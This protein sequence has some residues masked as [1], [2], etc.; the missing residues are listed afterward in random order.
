MTNISVFSFEDSEVRFVGTAEQ[1]EW[2]AQ[3]VFSVLG[4]QWDGHNLDNYDDDEKGRVTI[5]TPGGNQSVLTVT[6]PGLYRTIFKSRKP[7]AKRF[8]RWV[9]HDVLPSIRQTGNYTVPEPSATPSTTPPNSDTLLTV[10]EQLAVL[11]YVFDGFIH[12]G[13]ERKLVESA[14]IGAIA[15]QF[16]TMTPAL[17]S[18]K[19]ALMLQTPDSGRRYNPTELGKMLAAQL[20]REKPIRAADINQA[21]KQAGLQVCEH[22]TNAKG[23]KKTTWHLTPDGEKYGRVFLES[24]QGN[25]KTIPVIRWLPTVLEAIAAQF[26]D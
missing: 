13:V 16:P 6:E 26:A 15:A 23:E 24:A 8:Q 3:D 21:L 4:I 12:A 19:H 25:N 5:P 18:A 14:K 11:S 7:V 1:P 10:Q 22:H 17:E 9:F 2:V 20:G